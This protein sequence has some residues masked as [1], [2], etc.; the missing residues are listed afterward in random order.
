[1]LSIDTLKTFNVD[2]PPSAKLNITMIQHPSLPREYDA[3]GTANCGSGP[4]HHAPAFS[5]L[6]QLPRSGHSSLCCCISLAPIGRLI[7]LQTEPSN[8]F[9]HRRRKQA[10]ATSPVLLLPHASIS[11]PKSKPHGQGRDPSHQFTPQVP[12]GPQICSFAR[13]SSN[14]S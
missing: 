4:C 13:S 5:V 11:I 12:S 6:C 9:S 2:G 8:D 3:Y 14:N 10:I 7:F 1:M